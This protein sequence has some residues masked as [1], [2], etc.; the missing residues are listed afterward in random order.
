M[1]AGSA[2]I[3]HLSEGTDPELIEEYE[4]AR[5]QKLLRPRFCGIHCTALGPDQFRDWEQIVE[6]I[7]RTGGRGGGGERNDRLVPLLEPVALPRDDRRGLGQGQGDAR[8]PRRRL[9]A[10]GLKNLL[11]ELKVADM[12]NRTHLDEAS[13]PRSCARWP[14][15]TRPP[16][17]TVATGKNDAREAL[18]DRARE[19]LGT[20][21]GRQRRV[22]AHPPVRAG[23]GDRR[24]RPV[25]PRCRS[26]H[27]V[28]G[29]PSTLP[30]QWNTSASAGVASAATAPRPFAGRT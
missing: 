24:P 23:R 4:L 7:R 19:Q 12:W 16:F 22:R 10:L 14:L 27:P 15:A 8:L 26:V 17:I 6:E 1:K 30:P 5:A 21:Q 11:G 9:V 3:Y 25:R 18:K 28:G 20:N 29:S 2:F 13:R